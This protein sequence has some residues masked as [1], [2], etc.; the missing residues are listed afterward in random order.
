LPSIPTHLKRERKKREEMRK[1][2]ANM[3]SVDK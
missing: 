2:M 1:P 3:S